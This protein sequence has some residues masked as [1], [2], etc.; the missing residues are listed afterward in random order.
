M[1]AAYNFYVYGN[2]VSRCLTK[3]NRTKSIDG[4]LPDIKWRGFHARE[5]LLVFLNPKSGFLQNCTST[6]FLANSAGNRSKENTVGEVAERICALLDQVG[7]KAELYATGK[8]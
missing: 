4:S 5:E 8:F 1:I 7:T 2:A 3:F 6:A